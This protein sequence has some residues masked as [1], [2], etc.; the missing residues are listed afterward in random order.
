[1]GVAEAEGIISRASGITPRVLRARQS[2]ELSRHHVVS[3][4]RTSP[5]MKSR[6]QIQ[7]L[8][9]FTAYFCLMHHEKQ[10]IGWG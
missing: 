6:L 3:L 10:T 7:Y 2:L 5:C 8:H 4:R 1:M 9:Q